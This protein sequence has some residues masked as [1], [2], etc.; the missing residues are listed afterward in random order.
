MCFL[1]SLHQVNAVVFDLDGDK[2]A[3]A[4]G[5]PGL[6][7]GSAARHPGATMHAGD[8]EHVEVEILC[9]PHFLRTDDSNGNPVS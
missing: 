5:L 2:A 9:S 8:L 6:A 1:P 7:I 3:L 4:A